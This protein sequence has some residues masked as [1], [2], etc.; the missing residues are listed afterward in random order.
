MPRL[1]GAADEVEAIVVGAALRDKYFPTNSEK[2]PF[3][4]QNISRI[5]KD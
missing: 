3:F 4:R 5:L 2:F 1:R